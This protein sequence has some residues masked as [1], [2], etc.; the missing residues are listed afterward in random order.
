MIGRLIRIGIAGAA[1]AAAV[2]ALKQ[3]QEQQNV[4]QQP[5]RDQ[6]DRL[7]NE[8]VRPAGTTAA[9][10]G[11]ATPDSSPGGSNGAAA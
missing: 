8:P 10:T 4:A 2:R 7:P 9:P 11:R 1:G 3:R 5:L 6:P